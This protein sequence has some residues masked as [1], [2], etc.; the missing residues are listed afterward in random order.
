MVLLK[1]TFYDSLEC[2]ENL[3]KKCVTAFIKRLRWFAVTSASYGFPHVV[4]PL[5]RERLKLLPH[6][7]GAE[8]RTPIS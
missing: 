6:R 3:K 7:R 2:R 4:E 5:R 8:I 1:P